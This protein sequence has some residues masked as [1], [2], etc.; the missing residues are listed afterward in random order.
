MHVR[1]DRRMRWITSVRRSRRRTGAV[2]R[3]AQEPHR[4]ATS[5]E[6]F[7]DLCF[8]VAVAQA[9]SELHHLIVER[10]FSDG[11]IGFAAVFFGIWWAWVNYVWF[12]SGHDSDDVPYR[13]LTLVQIAGVLVLAAGIHDALINF[14]F[15]TITIGYVVMRLGLVG[16]WARVARDQPSHRRRAMRMV[17]G[18]TSV[19]VLWLLRLALP[20][21]RGLGIASFFV[22]ALIELAIPMWAERAAPGQQFHAG[23]LAERFGLFTI[24]VLGEVIL[25]STMAVREAIDDVGVELNVLTVAAAALIIAFAVWWSYFGRDD[26]PG[27]DRMHGA[28]FWGYGHL[29]VFAGLAAFGAGVHVAVDAAAGSDEVTAR[30]AALAVTI[31]LAVAIVGFTMSVASARSARERRLLPVEAGKLAIVLVLGLTAPMYVAIVG[32]AVVFVAG[33]IVQGIVLD[34]RLGVDLELATQ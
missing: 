25:S 2:L 9:A 12:A 11:V 32:T 24:I 13:L 26:E 21:D 33:T 6:L 30:V 7:Y 18:I 8:V 10:R 29:P 15:T 23:H 17:I 4:A 27:V 34:R 22:L 14:D 3:S 16:M 1:S 19:Q 5:L 20:D 31:P 28:F